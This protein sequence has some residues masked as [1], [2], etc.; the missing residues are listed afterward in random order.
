V[1]TCSNFGS[2][3]TPF[4]LDVA[5]VAS[6]AC[7]RSQDARCVNE[8]SSRTPIDTAGD[9]T[10]GHCIRSDQAVQHP[11]DPLGVVEADEEIQKELLKRGEAYHSQILWRE[12]CFHWCNRDEGLGSPAEVRSLMDD[13]D[14]VGVSY[15]ALEHALCAEAQPDNRYSEEKTREWVAK[16]PVPMAEVVEGSIRFNTLSCSHFTQGVRSIEAG[17]ANSSR[18]LGNGTNY[19]IGV[20]EEKNKQMPRSSGWASNGLS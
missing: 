8:T 10:N 7:R 12:L 14:F 6:V 20:I 2:K 13:V 9:R 5:P 18:R 16:S 1:P 11:D 4:C 15:K 3:F 17:V 19:D